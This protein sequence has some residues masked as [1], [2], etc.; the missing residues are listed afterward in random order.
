MLARRCARP[1]FGRPAFATKCG[2]RRVATR[3]WK[4]AE[5]QGL[6]NPGG[7]LRRQPYWRRG[8]KL[9]ALPS[10]TSS[11]CL[12]RGLIPVT[13]IEIGRGALTF[14]RRANRDATTRAQADTGD[15]D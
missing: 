14:G 10:S 4:R 9:A 5:P 1:L 15:E 11:V 3:R 6:V 8:V 7:D 2:M 13:R 12:P